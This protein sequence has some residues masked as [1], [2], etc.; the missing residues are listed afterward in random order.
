MAS[1]TDII[2]RVRFEIGDPP[3]PF[4]STGIGDGETILYDLPRQELN[5]G[6]LEVLVV[7]GAT[8]T[9]YADQTA[10]QPWSISTVYAVGAVVTLGTGFYKCLVNNTTATPVP[11][12]NSNWSDVTSTAYTVNAALGKILLGEPMPVNATLIATGTS[13]AL[14]SDLDLYRIVSDSCNQHVYGQEIEERYRDAH[15]FISFRETPKTLQNLPAIEEPL[16]VILSVIN[17]FWA[18]TNDAASDSNINTAEGTSIDRTTRYQHLMQ[19]IQAETQR[20]QDY[21]NQLNVGLY[22][23]ETLQ[24]RR[25]SRTTGRL[26]PLFKP[27]E[28][29]DHRWPVREIPAVDHRND[30]NSGVPSPLWSG[31]WG[32]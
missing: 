22:R 6:S 16:I 28:Y 2:S 21:C 9:S 17:C 15:G 23:T 4:R 32:S 3:Q 27:R 14:F 8:Q 25:S 1:I 24:L 30:D 18:L 10:A 26:V 5:E 31:N 12:G 13:W 29:D 11:G 19:Q 20:Y 7:N